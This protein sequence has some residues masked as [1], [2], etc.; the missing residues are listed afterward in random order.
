MVGRQIT[1]CKL[2]NTI[3]LGK[4]NFETFFIKKF[5]LKNKKLYVCTNKFIKAME[6]DVL[7]S[8]KGTRVVTAMHLHQM[9]ELPNHHYSINIRRWLK[10]VYEFQDGVRRPIVMK[11]YAL[12]KSNNLAVLEDYYLSVELAKVIAL[13][14]K[15]KAKLKL[16]RQLQEAE[17]AEGQIP[18]MSKEE[19]TELIDLV[20]AMSLRSCQE[21]S[22]KRHL[23]VY[24]T[25]NGNYTGNWWPYRA[26]LLGYSSEDLRDQMAAKGLTSKG[27]SQRQMLQYLDPYEVIRVAVMDHYMAEGKNLNYTRIMGDLAK[28]LAIELEVEILDDRLAGNLFAQEINEALVKQVKN[29]QAER[30]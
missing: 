29:L 26:T 3:H 16:A 15:S 18:R 20:K 14:S 27:K 1:L 12:R 17:A 23:E 21:A 30:A 10:D 9:L 5:V 13:H 7:I 24:S 25:R 8:K 22:E 19:M 2:S 4:R 11:D 6:L 28:T